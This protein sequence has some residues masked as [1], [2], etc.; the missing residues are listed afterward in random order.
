MDKIMKSILL[1]LQ[2][3]DEILKKKGSAR[4]YNHH[5]ILIRKN[6]KKMIEENSQDMLL[7]LLESENIS[8]R[9]DMAVM[10]YHCYADRCM[11][12]IKE[13]SEMTPENGLPEC[14]IDIVVSARMTLQYGIPDDFP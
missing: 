7:P 8:Y 12:I 11:K 6:V 1:S 14:Y 13:L 5:F 4:S 2:K 9:S 10:L 3:R